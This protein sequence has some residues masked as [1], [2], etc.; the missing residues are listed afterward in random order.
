MSANPPSRAFAGSAF[1]T[2][3]AWA[4][5]PER[6]FVWFAD[7]IPAAVRCGASFGAIWEPDEVALAEWPGLDRESYLR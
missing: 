4:N 3:A 1:R 2:R 6:R 5:L 7:A